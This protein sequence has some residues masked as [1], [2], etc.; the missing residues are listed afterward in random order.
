[1]G[2][3]NYRDLKLWQRSMDF[4]VNVY[5]IVDTF[6]KEENFGLYAQIKRS[7]VSI[8]SNISE[9]AGR[10]TNKQF[11]Y[12]LEVAMGSNNELQT[13]L[14][15]AVRFKYISQKTTELIIGE[16]SQVYKMTLSFYNTLGV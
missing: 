3:N 1:M 12:F 11:K 7:A 4:E 2:M 15:L 9:G 16:T 14:E 13:Q 6:L 8:P 10:A 5:K